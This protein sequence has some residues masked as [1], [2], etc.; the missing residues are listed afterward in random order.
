MM[1]PMQLRATQN[2]CPLC[3]FG[4][5]VRLCDS[6]IGV[7]CLRCGASAVAQS[8]GAVITSLAVDLA[9]SCVYELSAQGP[10]VDFLHARARQL[11]TSELLDGVPVGE[12]RAGIRCENVES[13]TF[14]DR[15]FDLC[16]STEVFEHV[17]D[18]AA[19]FGEIHRVL[20][21]GGYLVMTV[22]L[23]DAAQTLER[24]AVIDGRRVNTLPA[25]YHADRFRGTRVFCYR[26]YGRDILERVRR[27]GFVRADL[28][29]PELRLFGHARC[30]IV[31][32]KAR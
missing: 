24:T 32:E 31:A 9:G 5:A 22:P 29:R 6:D 26:N 11:I 25:E 20:K 3:G 4:I 23:S 19:G 14:A 16:T 2:T 8:L 30:V 7:R 13:L 17:A 27:A 18:D 1:R 12:T 10:I 21:P 28:V 15:T